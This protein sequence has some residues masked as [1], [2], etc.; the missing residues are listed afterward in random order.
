ME[1]LG[2]RARSVAPALCVAGAAL[3]ASPAA[4][5]MAPLWQ[6]D[7]EVSAEQPLEAERPLRVAIES[8]GARQMAARLPGV[9]SVS[10]DRLVV[11]LPPAVLLSRGERRAPRATFVVDYDSEPIAELRERFVAEHGASAGPAELVSFVRAHLEP[12]LSRGF[13]V[14]SRV[15]IHRSGDCTEYA[16]LLAALARSLGHPARVA[17]GT[18]IA[19]IGTELGA[20]GHA[21]TEIHHEGAWRLVDAT[22][23]TDVV[24][25]AYVPESLLE[26]EGPAYLFEL[27]SALKTGV[28]RI[29]VL[30]NAPIDDA[31]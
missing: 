29:E 16:V 14:A 6:L 18:L 17:I 10:D 3:I 31:S 13:D 20:F 15:A 28:L 22:P 11:D 2:R 8:R 4:A 26:E 19:K 5:Q 25:L 12:E 30:G 23:L 27:M 21:W 24:P 1:A 9:V 7:L